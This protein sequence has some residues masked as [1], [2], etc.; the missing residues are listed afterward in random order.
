MCI[1][2]RDPHY[3]RGFRFAVQ[4]LNDEGRGDAVLY[5]HGHHSNFKD[6]AASVPTGVLAAAMRQVEGKGE[7][8]NSRG[9]SVAPF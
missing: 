5:F 1:D 3:G 8:V 4:L 7:Y 2:D 9:E 6:A